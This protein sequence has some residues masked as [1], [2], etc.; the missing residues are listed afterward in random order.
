[1][2]LQRSQHTAKA[3]LLL[4]SMALFATTQ[5]VAKQAKATA[6]AAP[7]TERASEAA[8]KQRAEQLR[9][10]IDQIFLQLRAS[11]SLKE[12]IHDGN[13]VTP[14][15]VTYVPV[16]MSFEDAE[17]IVK[18]TGWKIEPSR[19][20]HISARTRMRD[21]L[22]DRKH[23][24]AVEVVPETADGFSVVKAVSATIYLVYLPNANNR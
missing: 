23:A 19:Q 15:V 5:S 3:I 6:N 24:L 1:M 8:L 7:A 12:S 22:F 2:L 14:I 21:G 4:M 17:V 9:A 18:A 13:D 20:G 16:G 11:K 10:A